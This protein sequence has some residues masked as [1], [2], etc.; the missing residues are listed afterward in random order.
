MSKTSL[1]QRVR[2]AFRSAE[3]KELQ[4]A[5]FTYASGALTKEGRKVVLDHIFENDTAV[6]AAMVEV[7]KTLNEDDCKNK[8]T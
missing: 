3:D 8:K 2:A 5:G 1:R 6:K 7:A 4:K